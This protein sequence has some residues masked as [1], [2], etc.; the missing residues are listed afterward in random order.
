M[1]GSEHFPSWKVSFKILVSE[2]IFQIRNVVSIK[3]QESKKFS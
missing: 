1:S 2:K 3:N